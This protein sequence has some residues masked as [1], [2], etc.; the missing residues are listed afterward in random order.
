VGA[1]RGASKPLLGGSW[2][3][4]GCLLGLATGLANLRECAREGE[5][6]EAIDLE[7]NN[8]D[9]YYA[10]DENLAEN[11]IESQNKIDTSPIAIMKVATW[12]DEPC[13][14]ATF[15][16]FVNGARAMAQAD[17]VR[18]GG[19]IKF[20]IS[21]VTR[22]LDK[23]VTIMVQLCCVPSEI[24]WTERTGEA[25]LDSI[26]MDISGIPIKR[27]AQQVNRATAKVPTVLAAFLCSAAKDG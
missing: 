14:P 3:P 26:S 17:A 10:Q 5:I 24:E 9:G 20:G 11:G 25:N 2:L 6:D 4:P 23:M 19:L 1:F 22:Q 7:W 21:S 16:E 18:G 8:Y 27:I 13:Q 12:W 15:A